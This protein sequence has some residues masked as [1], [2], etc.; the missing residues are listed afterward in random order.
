MEKKGT[1]S[2][3]CG[4]LF[5]IFLTLKLA[6]VGTVA[7]WSWWWIF[8]PIWIPAAIALVVLLIAALIYIKK[9]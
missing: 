5:L 3:L 7:A 6:Q 8:A 1:L 2:G 4:V 9:R